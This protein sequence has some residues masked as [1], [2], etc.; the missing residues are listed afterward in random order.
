MEAWAKAWRTWRLRVRASTVEPAG[1]NSLS[2]SKTLARAQHTTKMTTRRRL[3]ATTPNTSVAP[4]KQRELLVRLRDPPLPMLMFAKS[5]SRTPARTMVWM[6]RRS[7]LVCAAK[8]QWHLLPKVVLDLTSRLREGRSPASRRFR[9]RPSTLPSS[10]YQSQ[11]RLLPLRLL[12]LLLLCLRRLQKQSNQLR[13]PQRLRML[14]LLPRRMS[15]NL[16]LLTRLL[17]RPKRPETRRRIT[18]AGLLML[19]SSSLTTKS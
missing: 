3:T 2:T 13:L 10:L 5:A 11:W 6:K 16:Q 4:Q 8:T 14:S 19:S 17:N 7:I 12:F 9:E 18:F 15:R 1:T